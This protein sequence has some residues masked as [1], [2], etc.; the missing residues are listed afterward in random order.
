MR[1][2][3]APEGMSPAQKWILTD[4]DEFKKKLDASAKSASESFKETDLP[5]SHDNSESIK[6]NDDKGQVILI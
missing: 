2:A 5:T 6:E 3:S 1:Q 4:P